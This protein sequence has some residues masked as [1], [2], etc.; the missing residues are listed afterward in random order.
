MRHFLLVVTANVVL[1]CP[2]SGMHAMLVEE[3]TAPAKDSETLARESQGQDDAEARELL[4]NILA[5]TESFQP[6][7]VH[8]EM[9]GHVD[10]VA[11]Q[12]MLDALNKKH[13]QSGRKV[14][15]VDTTS[16][17]RA[18]WVRSGQ[19]ESVSTQ[20]ESSR[21]Q[22][23]LA[24]AVGTIQRVAEG[25]YN[26]RKTG[27][28]RI[29]R[30]SDFYVDTNSQVWRN[31]SQA[32]SVSFGSRI[33]PNVEP[34]GNNTRILVVDIDGRS[35]AQIEVQLDPP[36][37]LSFERSFI[38][39]KF[40]EVVTPSFAV[41]SSNASRYF[42]TVATRIMYAGGNEVRRDVLV[43]QKVEFLDESDIDST[44]LDVTLPEGAEVFDTVRER[45]VL[46]PAATSGIELLAEFNSIEVE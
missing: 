24:L 11:Q 30:P 46:L 3:G 38:G 44:V 9:T 39:Q 6:I 16:L 14:K 21:Q 31:L 28:A 20:G 8:Y 1:L 4:A 35:G 18:R 2:H 23:Y 7:R 22:L 33:A 37:V 40:L 36:R 10:P 29:L 45:A 34:P 13:E 42:P 26:I 17:L 5:S 27:R 32:K 19:S 43:C 15:P 25:K 12:R 41:D